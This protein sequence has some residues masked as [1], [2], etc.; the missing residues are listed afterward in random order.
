MAAMTGINLKQL[1]YSS[2]YLYSIFRKGF[3]ALGEDE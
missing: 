1:V 3:S 2:V